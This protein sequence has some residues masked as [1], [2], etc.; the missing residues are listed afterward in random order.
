MADSR[1]GTRGQV[2][3]RTENARVCVVPVISNVFTAR[4][5]VVQRKSHES[6]MCGY[7]RDL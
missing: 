2:L 1:A 3:V 5:N 7:V 6:R 4:A